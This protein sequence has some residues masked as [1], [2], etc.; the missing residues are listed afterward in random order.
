MDMFYVK[1]LS[2]KSTLPV[3]GSSQAAG[4]DLYSARDI[5][6]PAKG[7]ALIPTDLAVSIP[8]GTY[9][10]VAPRSGLALNHF[11]DCGA[12]VID[13]D[14][15]GPLGV[16]LFNFSDNDYK[17]DRIAQLILECIS[18][19]KVVEVEDLEVTNRGES[20]F[21]STGLR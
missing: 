20:G 2:E 18:T 21:G 10:R 12:G 5:I 4:Y 13:P 17:G 6:I 7:K 19:P 9:G 1:R 8:S 11:L 3:R 16:L 15:R 14:Y